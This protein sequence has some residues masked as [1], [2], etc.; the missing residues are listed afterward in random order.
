[1]SKTK[2][3]KEQESQL[4][5]LLALTSIPTAAGREHRVIDWL[6]EW[7]KARRNLICRRDKFGNLMVQI[8][9]KKSARPVIFTAH[10]DHPAFVITKVVDGRELEL[11]FRG[12]VR[13]AYFENGRIQVHDGSGGVHLAKIV[14]HGPGKVFYEARARL[15][16]ATDVVQ[17]DDIATWN[18]KAAFVKGKRVHTP[19]CDDL[20]A[21]AG[22][23]C[24]MDKLRKTRNIGDVRILFTRA[25]EVG[26][27]GAIH[28]AESGF[29]PKRARVI[30]LE[31]SRTFAESPIHGGPIVRVG[32]RISVFHHGLTF[33]VTQVGEYLAGAKGTRF[34][35]QRK[36]M[37]G[38]ACEA[39]AF[40]A[41]GYEAMCVCLPL[42]NYHNMGDID[43]V[44]AGTNTKPARVASEVI[45]LDDYY[46][47]IELLV[48]CGKA[49]S[50]PRS[51]SKSKSKG[52]NLPD[53]D[54]ARA[55]LGRMHGIRDKVRFVLDE[56]GARL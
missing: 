34:K 55:I 45:G 6:T 32:D 4:G 16:K 39:T 48:G 44:L 46:N 13:P 31:N 49:F 52:R 26:F 43:A 40:Q 7:L 1:M 38:G 42:A 30:A 5:D 12:G 19:A 17:V 22:A 21:A 28:A 47:L 23:L 11:E 15:S 51:L 54:G 53:A 56:K 37:P 25:E 10:L 27:L 14:A 50:M 8:K 9:G 3:K 33:A 29:M 24:A 20:A 18:L 41:F 2:L 36:L 35:F